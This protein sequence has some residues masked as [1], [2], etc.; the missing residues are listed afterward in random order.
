MSCDHKFRTNL[1]GL[2]LSGT[3]V[4]GGIHQ[5]AA[6]TPYVTVV[7][8]EKCGI[9]AHN[10]NDPRVGDR[11]Q[12]TQTFPV[13]TTPSQLETE[14]SR[15]SEPHNIEATKGGQKPPSEDTQQQ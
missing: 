5:K 2:T 15:A 6:L 12:R 13:L 1:D 14:K 4:A 11:F 7:F 8:C 10:G 9:L 3:T